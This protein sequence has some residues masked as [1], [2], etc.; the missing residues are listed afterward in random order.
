MFERVD[1]EPGHGDGG[2]AGGTGGVG[3][4]GSGRRRARGRLPLASVPLLPR[5]REVLQL[6]AGG[7]PAPAIAFVLGIPRGAV[8]ELLRRCAWRLGAADLAGAI[9]EARWRQL[10]A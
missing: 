9:A 3:G 6:A 7:F 8:E 10:L 5:E 4:S 2:G 1:V